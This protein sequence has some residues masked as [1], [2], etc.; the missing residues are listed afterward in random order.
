MGHFEH[1]MWH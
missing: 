1:L